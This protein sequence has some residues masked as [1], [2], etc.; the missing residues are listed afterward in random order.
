MTEFNLLDKTDEWMTRERFTAPRKPHLYPSE[1]SVEGIDDH[2]RKTVYGTCMRKAYLRV[3]KTAE[4]A[5]P[6][7]R[8]QWIFM[9]GK[10]IEEALVERWKQMGIWLENNLKFYWPEYNI[11]GEIDALLANP[12]TGEMFGVEVKTFYGYHGKKQIMGNT[13]QKGAPKMSHLLQSLIYTSYFKDRIPYWKMVYFARDEVA[14]REFNI[15]LSEEDKDGKIWPIIDGES[16]SKFSVND[17]LDRYTKLNEHIEKEIVPD[18]DYTLYYDDKRVEEEKKLGNVSKS[19][20]EKWQKGKKK[21]GDWQ[22]IAEGT[23]IKLESGLWKP[24]EHI[25]SGDQV[26]TRNG[27]QTV[28]RTWNHGPRSNLYAIKPYIL[29]DYIA[30]NDHK[31]LVGSANNYHKYKEKILQTT[32]FYTVE[33]LVKI[34]YSTQ[35]MYWAGYQIDT[36][37]DP[38]FQPTND[39]LLVLG[40]FIT[41]GCY[42]KNEDGN[43][44]KVQFT[45]HVDERK[46]AKEVGEAALRLGA[47]SY[48][49]KEFIDTRHDKTHRSL[50]LNVY[51]VDLVHF[52][53]AHIRGTHSYNKS[54]LE[55]VMK[56][57]PERQQ[58]LLDIMLRQD[59]STIHNRSSEVQNYTTTSKALAL[60][61][62]EIWLRNKKIASLVRQ[63]EGIA[64]FGERQYIAREAYHVRHFPNAQYNYG[65]FEGDLLYA[66]I[67]KIE[68]LENATYNVY[69]LSINETPEF[70]TQ[71]G[72]VHNCSYCPFKTY[73]WKRDG[74]P[75][76]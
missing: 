28:Q 29:D 39:E 58:Y 75:R 54:F 38:L 70:Q 2:G 16:F 22:C 49:I 42:R 55:Q 53:R 30:T 76:N 61:V 18:K 13:R 63:K 12:E 35:P 25:E 44:Y 60:Q 37:I 34:G 21:I 47:T 26:L 48:K 51:G 31:I 17:I 45:Y 64:E 10:I 71:G 1:A 69:D 52:L 11:S 24:I 50:Q 67:N 74:S 3:T 57:N 19:A 27:Y 43:T 36:R 20:Y 6:D 5:P 68:K 73:C 33:D 65:F 62:Q 59:G 72:I 14:R 41:E 9:Q 15:R 46:N 4:E 8:A 23:L 56:L 40:N 66:R 7:A 32:D